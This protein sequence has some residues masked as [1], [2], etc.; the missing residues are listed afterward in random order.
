[1]RKDVLLRVRSSLT[2]SRVIAGMVSGL[3]LMWL[4]LRAIRLIGA[5][6]ILLGLGL[7][8]WALVWDSYR[9]L[10]GVLSPIGPT[11]NSQ[12]DSR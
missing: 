5:S 11:S 3:L 7:L 8:L 4:P 1:M 6:L 9:A 12:D 2:P 10:S